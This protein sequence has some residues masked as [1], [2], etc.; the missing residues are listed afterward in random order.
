MPQ[1][2][3]TKAPRQGVLAT[4]PDEY[5]SP[6]KEVSGRFFPQLV[7]YFATDVYDRIDWSA[8]YEFLEQE[9]R[10]VLRDTETGPR[11]VDKV[12]KVQTLSGRPLYL[13]LHIEI[14]ASREAGFPLRMFV[15]YYRL[16]ELYPES[17][18][19]LAILADDDVGWK[20]GRYQHELLDTEV[21]FRYRTIKL[22]G[23]NE[24]WQELERDPNPFAL[25]VMAHLKT[26]ATRGDAAERL[27]WKVEL[28]RQLYGRG[29]RREDVLE[30]FRLIDWLL[31]LPEEM[32]KSFRQRVDNLEQESKMKYVTSIERLSRQEGRQEVVLSLI[33]ERFGPLDER[34]RKTVEQANGEQIL[35]WAK[36]LL[37]ASSLDEIF[38]T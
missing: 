15:Y 1:D 11:R 35:L 7:E 22:W 29:Y 13:V 12:V 19:S 9:L 24:R 6:W 5:D 37:N 23:Y 32:E 18:V 17:V 26:R 27:R 30:L 36:R 28:V 10:A 20:P 2:E 4:P 16:F 3:R 8:D 33:E 38:A 14:Q 34:L 31:A 21:T 25:V